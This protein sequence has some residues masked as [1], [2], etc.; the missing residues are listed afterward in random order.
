MLVLEAFSYLVMFSAHDAGTCFRVICHHKRNI[1]E[2]SEWPKWSVDTEPVAAPHQ[3]GQM[4]HT[5]GF[6]WCVQFVWTFQWHFPISRDTSWMDTSL[7]IHTE[8]NRTSVGDLDLRIDVFGD[9]GTAV[10]SW[11]R[12]SLPPK[13]STPFIKSYMIVLVHTCCYIHTHISYI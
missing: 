2:K 6:G 10:S 4:Q 1:F 11:Q 8:R 3:M 12:M 9:P 7:G 13:P 5:A